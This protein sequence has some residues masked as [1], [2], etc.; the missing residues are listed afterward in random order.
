MIL[1]VLSIV[2]IGLLLGTEFAVSAF[3]N[4]ILAKL[5]P[6]AEAHA[7]SLFAQKLGKMMPF[8]YGLNLLLLIIEAV[9]HLHDSGLPWFALAPILWT[10]VIVFTVLVLVPINN[11]ISAMSPNSYSAEL[12]QEHNRWD[13]LHR[14]RVLVL[15]VAMIALLI[16]IHV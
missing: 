13:T 1:D 10:A 7:T 4:P 16:G 11:R 5:E 14:W 3:I 15:S 12:R 9:I 2:S 8:W 6:A